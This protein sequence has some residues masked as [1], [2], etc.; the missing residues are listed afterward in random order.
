MLW[1]QLLQLRRW[2]QALPKALQSSNPCASRCCICTYGT[3]A[4]CR[5]RLPAVASTLSSALQCSS[6]GAADAV[7]SPVKAA[8]LRLI[9]RGISANRATQTP[10]SQVRVDMNR[11]VW[12]ADYAWSVQASAR[13]RCMK[14]TA[15]Q[16]LL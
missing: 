9:N 13:N 5:S 14:R 12:L 10:G 11:E 3:R 1:P 15:C 7:I 16:H 2:S 4:V 6:P 8:L